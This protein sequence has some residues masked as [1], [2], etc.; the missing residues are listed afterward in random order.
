[1]GATGDQGNSNTRSDSKKRFILNESFV[2]RTIMNLDNIVDRQIMKAKRNEFRYRVAESLQK[3]PPAYYQKKLSSTK[4]NF[5]KKSV[6][7]AAGN[8]QDDNNNKMYFN[9]VG[10]GGG[11]VTN[12]GKKGA[13]SPKSKGNLEKTSNAAHLKSKDIGNDNDI[14]YTV[15]YAESL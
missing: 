12:G 1:M 9:T 6:E 3:K 10:G 11:G 14:K 13:A 4:S 5:L 2:K 15:S 8:T 7:R